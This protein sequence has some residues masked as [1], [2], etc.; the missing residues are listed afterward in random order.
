MKKVEKDFEELLRL[1]NKHRVHYCIIGAFAVSFHAIPRYTKDLDVIVD[2]KEDNAIHIIGALEEF[3]FK[4]LNLCPDDFL[5]KDGVIQLGFE[6]VRIDILT[7]VE[8][9]DFDDI[10]RGRK[11]GRYG[12]ELVNFAGIDALIRM[13]EKSG[14]KQDEADIEILKKSKKKRSRH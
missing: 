4:S 7:S 10:W 2:P 14:R 9:M 11:R 5:R 3:G 1:F 6:P 13:K 8:G 12:R